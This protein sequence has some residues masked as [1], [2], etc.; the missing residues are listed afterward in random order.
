MPQG[1]YHYGQGRK[2]YWFAAQWQLKNVI[3]VLKSCACA[4]HVLSKPSHLPVN[5]QLRL[6]QLT[7]QK[8]LPKG[9]PCAEMLM[10]MR[11][12]C[13][14]KPD[15]YQL[16]WVRLAG[17]GVVEAATDLTN[18]QNSCASATHGIKPVTYQLTWVRLAGLA[19]QRQLTNLTNVQSSCACATLESS[20]TPTS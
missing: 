13:G 2:Y 9:Y 14:I 15:T 4:T 10:R 3:N 6:A 16:T 11:H 18:V 1:L 7:M 20:P 12:T 5:L 17:V 8:Q 19:L